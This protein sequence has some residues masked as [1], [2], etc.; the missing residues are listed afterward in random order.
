MLRRYLRFLL[1]ILL[2]LILTLSHGVFPQH[3]AVIAS[4][5]SLEE[6]Q[7]KEWYQQGNVPKAIA[8]WQQTIETYQE[9][10]DILS[11][12]RVL[13]YLAL[14]YSQLAEWQKAETAIDKSLALLQSKTQTADT[15][16]ILAEA[17]NIQ[18]TLQLAKGNA[19]SALASWE[20]ATKI[21]EKSGDISG[22]IRTK[23]NQG[24]ALKALGLYERAC[25]T[26]LNTLTQTSLNCE[27]LT[28]DNLDPLF[29][30]HLTS[31][32]KSGWLSLGEI[33]RQEGN[34][35]ASQWILTRILT[36]LSS[37]ENKADIILNL[38]QNLELLQEIEG[39]KKYYQQAIAEAVTRDTKLKAQ[40]AQ[41]NL[42]IQQQK[43][44]EAEKLLNEIEN[45]LTQFNLN[46]T[47]I[48]GQIY[49]AQLLLTWSQGT[50]TIN[51]AP[52]WRKIQNLL[53]KAQDNSLRLNY[54]QGATYALGNLGK[55]YEI[56]A[57]TKSCPNQL[58]VLI[59]C[60][61]TY[62]F[63]DINQLI[64][65]SQELRIKAKQLTEQA[66]LKSQALQI[67]STT[68]IWQWQLGRILAS[69]DDKKAAI[70]AYLEA[71][72]DL[73]SIT[74]DLSKNRTFQFS[75]QEKVE[76][77]YRELLSLLLPQNDQEAVNPKKLKEARTQIEALQAAEL[78]NFFQDI[79]VV[80]QPIDVAKID[81]TAAILYPLILRDRLVVILSLPNKPLQVH[82]TQISQKDLEKTVQEFRY[83][84]VIRSQREFFT[85][86]NIIY[87]WLVKPF[88]TNLQQS[89]IKTLVFV[90]DGVFRN[91]PMNALYD[92][93]QYL[94]EN[95]QVALSPGLSL[96]SPQPL[97]NQGLKT[98]FSGLTETFQQKG[99]VPL[100]YVR[101]EL[102]AVQSQ[103]PSVALINE[104]FTVS[105][106]RNT[107]DDWYFPIVHLA[108]HGQFSSEFEETFI[109]AWNS[110]INVLE[111]E[112]ILKE[113]DPRGTEPI[114]LLILSA[115]ET[116]SGDNRA[117]LG[118]AGFAVRAGARST[119]ATLWSVNDEAAAVIMEQFYQQLSTKQAS[120]AEALRQA[121]L[122]MLK[123]RWYQHP[124]Y[125]S[126]Y[127]LVGNWL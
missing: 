100:F 11:Q 46:Q 124:F 92:G 68:Y 107:L 114:E 16:P 109:V 20:K 71:V 27:A 37:T 86:G 103:V 76:P 38:G 17:L 102:E 89:K 32:E 44:E 79:C 33:L 83:Q 6:Q 23:I 3:S 34:I 78:N 18:G 111:L 91:I 101:Q 45:N 93:K 97:Q 115:C 61:I 118:L 62:Q 2:S 39:A 108:T 50:S 87:Q 122:A 81:E 25:E 123:N 73:K 80:S 15:L 125:W 30:T 104:E 105:N 96:L 65:T 9:R 126:A 40:L 31:L 53:E 36:Q 59:N 19:L 5:A 48:D 117:A 120:K 52:S 43:W 64:L 29:P 95:Y 113:N 8:I 106:L 60:S 26:I 119:L 90:P 14:A 58:S 51:E 67:D 72:N 82:V 41:L 99:L 42:L 28:P 69:L 1:L 94:I 4:S 7:A 22:T 121:Q 55:L 21:H 84:I 70:K 13:S 85:Y 57:L 47:K 35:E 24:R 75:F 88:I 74:V 56:L 66:L 12:G 110:L 54:A 98:L 10:G 116:A 112:K 127:T 63:S 77:V 49:L